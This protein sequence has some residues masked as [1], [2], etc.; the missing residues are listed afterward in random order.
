MK[1]FILS[2]LATTVFFTFSSVSNGQIITEEKTSP[3]SLYSSY[4]PEA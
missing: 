1:K 2:I 3:I 4:E